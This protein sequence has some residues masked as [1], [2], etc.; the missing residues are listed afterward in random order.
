MSRKSRL[1]YAIAI[2]K[3]HYISD[4][5]DTRILSPSSDIF[6]IKNIPDFGNKGSKYFT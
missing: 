4:Q 5:R 2:T 3:I 1:D 6:R